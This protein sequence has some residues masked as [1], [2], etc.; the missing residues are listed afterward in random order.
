MRK[1]ISL[2][3]FILFFVGL[4]LDINGQVRKKSSTKKTTKEKKEQVNLM[5]KINP[6]IKFGNLGFFNGFSISSK[7]NIGYKLSER[8]TLGLGGKLFFDQIVVVGASDPSNFDY[9][10]LAFAR[11]K[12]T[13]DIYIQAEYAFM[14]YDFYETNLNYPLI[15]AGY[16]SGIG[17]WR[18]GI[19]LLYIANEQARDF[20]GSIVEYWFGASYNF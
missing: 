19:E 4:S 16:M 15:G 14:K 17:K 9:G 20:Q 18:F 8:F 7:L 3:V 11:G 6:E 1:V 2:L 12:V 10:G 5:D 13:N